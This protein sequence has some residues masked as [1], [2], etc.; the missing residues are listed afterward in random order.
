MNSLDEEYLRLGPLQTRIDIH[1]QYSEIPQDVEQDVIDAGS[2][3]ASDDLLDV[4]C[5]TGGFVSRLRRDG[6]TGRL[7]GL[8]QSPAAVAA[9]ASTPGVEG[10]L[11][12][13]TSLPF[14]EAEFDVVCARHMLYHVDDPVAAIAQANRVLRGHGRFVATVNN[15]GSTPRIASVVHEAAVAHGITPPVLPVSLVHSDNLPELIRTGFADV[16]TIRC[17]NALVFDDP[18]PVISFG[19]ALMNFYGV[20]DEDPAR[21]AVARTIADDVNAWFGANDGPWRDPKGYVV[22][23]ARRGD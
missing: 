11:G 17:D 6:H 19:L 4:G 16:T 15:P 2:I 23:V 12:S 14:E 3:H 8:D 18:R 22:C 21:D 1:R 10:I 20:G 9:A 13:A 7:V 5:G